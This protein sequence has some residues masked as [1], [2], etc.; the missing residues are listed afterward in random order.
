MLEVKVTVKGLKEFASRMEPFKDSRWAQGG[1]RE[2]IGIISRGIKERYDAEV[3]PDYAPW[4]PLRPSTL[5]RKGGRGKKLVLSGALRGSIHVVGINQMASKVVAAEMPGKFHQ[6]G[7]SRMVIRS[8]MGISSKDERQVM[9]MMR[10]RL[11][12]LG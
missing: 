4:A 1:I 9:N 8:F 7:T 6:G 10:R 2:G 5:K 12:A 11:A 3:N